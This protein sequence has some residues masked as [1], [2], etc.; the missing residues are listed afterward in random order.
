MQW[1][2]VHVGR[3]PCMLSKFQCR[4]LVSSSVLF[5]LF[6][7]H[8]QTVAAPQL[9][10]RNSCGFFV[11]SSQSLFLSCCLLPALDVFLAL[12]LNSSNCQFT[13]S[14]SLIRELFSPKCQKVVCSPDVFYNKLVSPYNRRPH[15][16][17]CLSC[18]NWQQKGKKKTPK[19][20]ILRKNTEQWGH[21]C[22]MQL[23]RFRGWNQII[24][25]KH[26][27]LWCIRVCVN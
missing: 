12:V 21:S 13:V 18:W 14:G 4:G 19:Q 15:T 11:Y 22:C 20:T 8:L 3:N 27:E 26:W 2:G 1:W 17:I 16:K 7:T 6:C 10:S 25:W 9:S 5:S 23:Q 24:N